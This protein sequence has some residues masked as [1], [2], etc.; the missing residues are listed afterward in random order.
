MVNRFAEI[1]AAT[2]VRSRF[3]FDVSFRLLIIIGCYCCLNFCAR[4]LMRREEP[5]PN[6]P[7]SAGDHVH[8]SLPRGTEVDQAKDRGRSDVVRTGAG[9]VGYAS[10][11]GRQ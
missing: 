5:I 4:E 9:S 7:P 10:K 1:P 6:E 2:V 11:G 3:D 8:A